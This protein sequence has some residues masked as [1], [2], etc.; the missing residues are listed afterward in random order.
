M[1]PKLTGAGSIPV[2]RSTLKAT[3]LAQCG[4]V[5]PAR[6][7]S[8]S[9]S[10]GKARCR[11]CQSDS[12]AGHRENYTEQSRHVSR[13]IGQVADDEQVKAEQDQAC[14]AL[15]DGMST[16][17]DRATARCSSASNVALDG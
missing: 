10:R 3:S 2:T 4:R 8:R 7:R 5:L 6:W 9:R 17:L 1:V 12:K 14:G 13:P 11:R 16:G 15:D